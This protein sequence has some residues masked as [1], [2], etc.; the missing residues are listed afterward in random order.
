MQ[1]AAAGGTIGI[2]AL[3][4]DLVGSL[5]DATSRQ[6]VVEARCTE[7]LDDTTA[8][9]VMVVLNELMTNALKHSTG[10]VTVRCA[11]D[12]ERISIEVASEATL[13]DEFELDETRGFGIMMIRTI[14]EVLGGDVELA[15]RQPAVIRF[16]LPRR[17]PLSAPV[18]A[19]SKADERAPAHG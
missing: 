18:I 7:Q 12:A 6:I 2:D 16:L 5:A 14:A 1:I 4:T 15:S 8:I 3:L 10:P 19:S 11:D 17:A 13:A 9:H